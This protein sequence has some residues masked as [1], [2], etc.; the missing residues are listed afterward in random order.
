[1]IV[2]FRDD[3]TRLFFE[4]G[5]CQ[6]EWETFK[7]VAVR[8]LDYLNAARQLKDLGCPPGN[9]LEPLKGDREGQ[10]SIRI[11]VQYRIC[12]KWSDEGPE[13][14]QIIDYHK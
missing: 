13:D 12:F 2:S 10:H 8:K 9:K 3:Y 1:M 6:K 5:N 11:N 4:E 7:R 14:V